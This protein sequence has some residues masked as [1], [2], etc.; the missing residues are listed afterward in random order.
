MAGMT[1]AMLIGAGINGAV[2]LFNAH[3]AGKAADK[4]VTQQTASAD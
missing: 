1:T 3:K 4:A 2:G